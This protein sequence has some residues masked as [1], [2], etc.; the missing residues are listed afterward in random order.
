M[1]LSCGYRSVESQRSLF[2][3]HSYTNAPSKLVGVL[4]LVAGAESDNRGVVFVGV[5]FVGLS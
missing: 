1:G 4:W 5:V 3:P 2:H